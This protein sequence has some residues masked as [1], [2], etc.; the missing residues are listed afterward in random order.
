MRILGM[1]QPLAAPCG[2]LIAR[3]ES[4]WVT[5]YRQNLAGLCFQRLSDA[6]VH[7]ELPNQ[8]DRRAQP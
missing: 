3:R 2:R 1:P 4:G 7:R 8:D 6:V 5:V